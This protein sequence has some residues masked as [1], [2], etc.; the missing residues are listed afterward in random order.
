[1]S[2]AGLASGTTSASTLRMFAT[3]RWNDQ[4]DGNDDAGRGDGARTPQCAAPT[5]AQLSPAPAGSA[6]RGVGCGAGE[7]SK[8]TCIQLVFVR[9]ILIE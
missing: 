6:A 8:F 3:R 4:V 7:D 2:E 5:R 1:V 9:V